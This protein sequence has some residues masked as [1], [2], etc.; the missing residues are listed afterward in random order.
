MFKEERAIKVLI[1]FEEKLKEQGHDTQYFNVAYKAL[2]KQVPEKIIYKDYC[3]SCKQYLG[4]EG[5]E[6]KYC[7]E[8]GQKLKWG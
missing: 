2:E 3:P 1:N 4:C 5:F 6:Q 7:D 8:C